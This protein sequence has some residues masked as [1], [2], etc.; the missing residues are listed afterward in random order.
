MKV[1]KCGDAVEFCTG[2]FGGK[3]SGYE[4]KLLPICKRCQ[5]RETVIKIPEGVYAK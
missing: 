4:G 5:V 3:G 1:G 2:M